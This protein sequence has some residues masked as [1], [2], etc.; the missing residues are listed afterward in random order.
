MSRGVWA[1]FS[2]G[3]SGGVP[4]RIGIGLLAAL[5]LG[6]PSARAETGLQAEA[7][8]A[9]SDAYLSKA[10]NNRQIVGAAAG[11]I[12][13]GEI[14]FLRGYGWQDKAKGIPFDPEATRIRA[15]SISKTFTATAGMQL[16]ERGLLPSLDAP[17]NP[18]LKRFKLP[19]PH[20]DRVTLRQLMTHTAGMT[21]AAGT[22]QGIA[23]DL[24]P[25]VDAAELGLILTENIVRKPGEIALYSNLGVAMQGALIED[26][27]GLSLA[28]YM[29]RELFAPLGLDSAVL[30]SDTTAP[31]NLARPYATFPNGELQDVPYYPKHPATAASGGL[32]ITPADLLRW[33]AFHAD[34]AG[35]TYAEV[36]SGGARTAMGLPQFAPHPE[37]S[38]IGLQF[39]LSQFGG[40]RVVH[41]SCGLPGTTS[42]LALL[43]DR[44]VAVVISVLSARAFPSVA[45]LFG[46]LVDSGRLVKT[47]A[48]PQGPLLSASD[49]W[50]V[51]ATEL[52]GE[53]QFP[54]IAPDVAAQHPVPALSE[55]SG[56]YWTERRSRSSMRS[57]VKASLLMKVEVSADGGVSIGGVQTT[58]VADGVFERSGDE[59]QTAARFVFSKPD[60][61]GPVVMLAYG[62][63]AWTK[64]AWFANPELASRALG[65]GLMLSIL[66]FGAVFWRRGSRFKAWMKR[67]MVAQA[68]VAITLPVLL[69][70]GYDRISG[71]YVDHY[72]NE[73]LRPGLLLSG[74]NLHLVFG[75]LLTLGAVLAWV[76]NNNPTGPAL[77]LIPRLHLTFMATLAVIS[78]PAYWLFNLI[79]FNLR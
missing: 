37:S 68:L 35:R 61:D 19:P 73:L 13:E 22:P 36:L 14:V 27:T 76:R 70:A 51:M 40:E 2:A 60:A 62:S 77:G 16:V 47:E 25:P 6:G 52:I 9:W 42:V 58:R 72:N 8:A 57:L 23:C 56:E 31:P 44:E 17:I 78:W 54:P 5:A 59:G 1:S 45:D 10:L 53:K 74:L 55:L 21:G 20:G 15:C 29:Q 7:L 33:A 12:R 18:Y 63:S 34:T 49:I 30:H 71:I 46:Q 3:L 24:E 66:G 26:V 64:V 43:P 75:V 41:H 79:G 28:D 67:V 32:I 69:F 4:A 65:I 11:L 50:R 38:P 39:H 48:G